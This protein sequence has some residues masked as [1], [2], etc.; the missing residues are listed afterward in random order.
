MA[1]TVNKVDNFYYDAD[2][3]YSYM[4]EESTFNPSVIDSGVLVDSP[5]IA[6]LVGTQGNIFTIPFYTN[7]EGTEFNYNGETDIV[8]DTLKGGKQTGMAFRRAASW[9]DKDF[10]REITGANPLEDCAR[11][12]AGYWREKNQK[13]LI[14]LLSM[15][16]EV[17]GLE[18]HITNIAVTT[19]TE[20]QEENLLSPE[21]TIDAMQKAFGDTQEDMALAI[22]H[23][24]VYAQL[25]KKNL[26]VNGATVQN[27]MGVVPFIPTYLGMRV[28][29][30]D[31][32]TVGTGSVSTKKE[33]TTIISGTGTI[34]TC[35][36]RVEVPIE[37]GRDAKSKGGTNYLVSRIGRVMHPNGLDFKVSDIASESPTDEE[38]TN[39]ANWTLAVDEKL[40]RIAKIVTNG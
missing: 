7:L 40:I 14:G 18:N 1:R 36:V 29:V 35:P 30:N 38:L 33:Y 37:F 20:P 32:I 31:N 13:R 27:A 8:S 9:T 22:M 28:I 2:V 19:N 16:P 11:K 23:S 10:T 15:V 39:K 17:T 6:S 25:V 26:I 5:E 12:V 24:V 34:L 4:Q 21:V 3:F